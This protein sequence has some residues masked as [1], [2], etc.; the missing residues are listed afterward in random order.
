M[1]SSSFDITVITLS[2]GDKGKTV[3]R[4]DKKGRRMGERG[5][6]KKKKEKERKAKYIRQMNDINKT[7]DISYRLS[8]IVN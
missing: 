6:K 7:D 1:S 5:G 2:N 8:R 4:N 3:V